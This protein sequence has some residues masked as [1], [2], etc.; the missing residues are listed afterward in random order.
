MTKKNAQKN[1]KDKKKQTQDKETN[2]ELSTVEIKTNRAYKKM[3]K[4]MSWTV[5]IAFVLVILLPEF[6]KDILDSITRYIFLVGIVTL[7]VFIIIEFI[8]DSIKKL[9]RILIIKSQGDN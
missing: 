4:T 8:G 2:N 3:L 9:I 5:G 1:I 7:L 6:N